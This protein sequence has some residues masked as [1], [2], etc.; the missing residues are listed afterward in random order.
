MGDEGFNDLYQ[1]LPITNRLQAEI[2]AN[3]RLYNLLRL[4]QETVAV[5]ESMPATTIK[6]VEWAKISSI[7][8]YILGDVWSTFNTNGKDVL[9][10]AEL[11]AL[12]QAEARVYGSI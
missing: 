8:N 2:D 3:A 1:G 10:T 4:E 5:I 12:Q 7:M 9:T 6:Q 11:Y